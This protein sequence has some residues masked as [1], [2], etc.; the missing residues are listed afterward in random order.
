MRFLRISRCRLVIDVERRDLR[1]DIQDA[2]T[3]R[4]D[5][6][7]LWLLVMTGYISRTFAFGGL[8]ALWSGA[9][10]VWFLDENFDLTLEVE[11]GAIGVFEDPRTLTSHEISWIFEIAEQ[12]FVE[13]AALVVQQLNTITLTIIN[14]AAID[15]HAECIDGF[16]ITGPF[17]IHTTSDNYV[18]DGLSGCGL[19]QNLI[20]ADRHWNV[21]ALEA[22]REHADFQLGRNCLVGFHVEALNSVGT[23][24][25]GLELGMERDDDGGAH[26][27]T[28]WIQGSRSFSA[29]GIERKVDRANSFRLVAI[30]A[31]T[32]LSIQSLHVYVA[33]EWIFGIEANCD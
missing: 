24:D 21:V 8:L 6:G 5:S 7:D 31:A 17:V 16:G 30:C 4:L 3:V 20:T 28:L 27:N 25:F 33:F 2:C 9:L 12:I 13:C 23:I 1:P 29:A 32:G 11:S 19:V 26:E 22:G 14:K 15:T 18:F 10:T